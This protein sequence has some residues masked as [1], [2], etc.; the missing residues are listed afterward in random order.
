MIRLQDCNFLP[1]SILYCLLDLHT[2]IKQAA[3]LERS[4]DKQQRVVFGA[5]PVRKLGP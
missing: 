3:I 5:Q 2:L 4:R 1:D